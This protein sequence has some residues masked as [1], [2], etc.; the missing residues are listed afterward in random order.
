MRAIDLKSS[1]VAGLSGAILLIVVVHMF[2]YIEKQQPSLYNAVPLTVWALL[3][4]IVGFSVQTAERL[5][6]AS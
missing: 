6:G 5:T 2:D 1:G 3:G 4:F